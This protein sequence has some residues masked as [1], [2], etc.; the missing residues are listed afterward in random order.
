MKKK[1]EVMIRESI[2][3]ESDSKVVV[4]SRQQGDGLGSRYS[5]SSL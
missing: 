4:L 1:L 2:G 3:G 5:L